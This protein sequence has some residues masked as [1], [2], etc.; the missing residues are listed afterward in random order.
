MKCPKCEYLGFE[1]VE[2][3]R[4]CGYDFSLI[5][6]EDP[7][8]LPIRSA[9]ADTMRPLEDLALVD[10]PVRS[11]IPGLSGDLSGGLDRGGP[12]KSGQGL[13]ELPLFGPVMP[14]DLPLITRLSP[15]RQPLSVRRASVDVPR[16][17]AGQ[18]PSVTGQTPMFDLALGEDIRT[19]DLLAERVSPARAGNPAEPDAGQAAGIGARMLAV[20]IDLVILGGIDVAVIYFTI[21]ICGLTVEDLGILPKGPLVAFLLVQNGGYLVA[22]TAGGQTLGKMAMGIRVVSAHPDASVDLGHSMVRTIVWVL[23]AVPA[24]LGFVTAIFSP[25]RRGLHDR[26]AGTRVVRAGA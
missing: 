14:D 2:R 8:D 12:A 23:L 19:P 9:S 7:P 15:P 6:P 11:G 1:R 21:Q 5:R 17:R 16:L 10:A 25:D 24:G 26:C 22:F 20:L 13:P 18:R 4:N 3:C